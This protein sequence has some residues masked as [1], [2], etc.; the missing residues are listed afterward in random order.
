M[1]KYA[2]NNNSKAYGMKFTRY[3]TII[4]LTIIMEATFDYSVPYDNLIY[5]VLSV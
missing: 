5:P 3:L 4:I 2:Y 1:N